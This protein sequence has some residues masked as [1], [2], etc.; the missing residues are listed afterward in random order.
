MSIKGK[1]AKV[2]AYYPLFPKQRTVI[3]ITD[4]FNGIPIPFMGRREEV[5][6][7]IEEHQRLVKLGTV[8]LIYIVGPD[9]IGKSRFISKV[10]Q[11]LYAGTTEVLYFEAGQ[12]NFQFLNAI[13]APMRRL[14]EQYFGDLHS[15]TKLLQRKLTNSRD[16]ETIVSLEHLV[17]FIEGHPLTSTTGEEKRN[18]QQ[19]VLYSLTQAL[20]FLYD[21]Q[22]L[23]V[24][25]RLDNRV[26]H[27]VSKFLEYLRTTNAL[28]V[29]IPVFIEDTRV[30]GEASSNPHHES[31]SCNMLIQLDPLNDR[32]MSSLTHSLL[33]TAGGAPE[34]LDAWITEA[35][36]GRPGF[37]VEYLEHLVGQDII[38]IDPS[39]GHWELPNEKPA[40]ANL[41]DSIN[42]VLQTEIDQLSRE[43]RELL[44][45]SSILDKPFS[46]RELCAITQAT[47][48]DLQQ[49]LNKFVRRKLLRNAS[50]SSEE[51]FFH[52]RNSSLR[53]VA[54][55]TLTIKD[56]KTAHLQFAEFLQHKDADPAKIAMHYIEAQNWTEALRWT[57]ES[58]HIATSSFSLRRSH[59]YLEEAQKLYEKSRNQLNQ[60]EEVLASLQ[61]LLVK[62][63]IDFY[64]GDTDA[65]RINLD[66]VMKGCDPN[67]RTPTKRP[68]EFQ[69]SLIRLRALATRLSGNLAA[70]QNQ[71]GLSV[72]YFEMALQDLATLHRPTSELCSIEASIT[73]SLM[74]DGQ[75]EE[76]QLRSERALESMQHSETLSPMMRNAWAR[77]YD[78]LGRIAMAQNKLDNAHA[79]FLAA[80]A[81]RRIS[82]SISLL[83]HSTGNIAGVLAL[84][85]EWRS[86]AEAFK[87]VAEQWASLGNL[88]MECIGRLNLIECLLELKA[89]EDESDRAHLEELLEKTKEL[90]ERLQSPQLS[91]IFEGHLERALHAFTTGTNGDGTHEGC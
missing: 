34:W 67:V 26:D 16:G 90:V 35:S 91:G 89:T 20:N 41:P 18:E 3:D 81:L 17:R 49:A 79:Q 33:Q 56:R 38:Q 45:R 61:L 87:Q 11:R 23:I 37:A 10:I 84:K 6:I 42:V 29:N 77:H 8:S 43:E 82:G 71:L 88:E 57:L 62:S 48:N 31:G 74:L 85:G 14:I 76:A 59:Q 2:A 70:R 64:E 53:A 1:S 21:R 66:K 52:F 24:W 15:F 36:S 32:V 4:H 60:D 22:P 19:Q 50:D 86:S 78:T 13:V 7:T 75:T 58:I 5:D 12:G 9:S 30:P 51:G 69:H 47:E 39:L 25:I 46:M 63:E 55:D 72:Q 40:D 80:Q 28:N 54:R 27:D 65:A 44:C 73:W 83:A 68:A